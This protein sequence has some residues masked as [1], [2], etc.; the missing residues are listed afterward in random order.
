MVT[1]TYSLSRAGLNKGDV[2]GGPKMI[3]RGG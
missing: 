2:M 3:M 1:F